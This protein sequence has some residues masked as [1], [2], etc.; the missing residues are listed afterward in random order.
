MQIAIIYQS[1]D[2]TMNR[3]QFI[4]SKGATCD[5]WNWSWSFINEA[6]RFVVFGSW[7]RYD[8]GEQALIF[9]TDW[10]NYNGRKSSGY[11]Q[12]REH[13]RL[14]EDEGYKLKTFTMIYS[15]EK[16]DEAGEGPATISDFTPVL[17]DKELI[18]RGNNWF[19]VTSSNPDT[20]IWTDS[21]LD[22]CVRTYLWMLK[23][24]TDGLKPIKSKIRKALLAG[25]LSHRSDGSIEYRFQN[26]SSVL[27]ERRETWIDGYKP[28]ENVGSSTTK[29]ISDLIDAYHQHRHA[30]RLN[31][32]V[33]ALPQEAVSDAVTSLISGS[34]F[35]YAESTD[36]DLVYHGYPLPPKKVIG[37]ASKNYFGASLYS[38]NFNGGANTACFNKLKESGFVIGEK[39]HDEAIDPESFDFREKVEALKS[40]SPSK[41]PKGNKRP[42][43]RSQIT[44]VTERDT[45]VVAFVE[46]R[47][48][49]VCELCGN[50]APFVRSKDNTPFLEVHHIIPLSEDGPDTVDN[51]AALCPNCH[52]ACHYGNEASL[53]RA[54]LLQ[55]ITNS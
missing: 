41:P 53:L 20:N 23:A 55:K 35:E 40:S 34:K 36:Y 1:N 54:S 9:S 46:K 11:K 48:K 32:L 49:G 26:I 15:E 27:K 13:L 8:D 6:D 22:A 24:E 5:N 28:A 42:N 4:E 51:A 14:L 38:E 7:D 25:P 44:V 33:K 3:K 19:A 45:K 21:E 43:K 18:R 2:L 50:P 39:N 12:S 10:E 30:R 17:I 16:Q 37:Y 52:R 31:W 29:K 47:A